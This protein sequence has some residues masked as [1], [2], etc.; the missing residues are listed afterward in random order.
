MKTQKSKLIDKAARGDIEAQR[1]LYARAVESR[2][3]AE[4]LQ[5][6]T[7]NVRQTEI[8]KAARTFDPTNIPERVYKATTW[9]QITK[10]QGLD[11]R[12]KSKDDED[13]DAK[14]EEDEYQA[15]DSKSEEDAD[16][17]E[18]ED[19]RAKDDAD[20]D[21]DEDEVE[22]SRARAGSKASTPDLWAF[23]GYLVKG[24]GPREVYGVV[25]GPREDLDLQACDPTWLKSALPEWMSRGN[26][27]QMH[28]GSM[29]P[30]GKAKKLV[31]AADGDWYLTAK[32]LDDS[33]WKMIQEQ[34]YTGF[35]VGVKNPIVSKS[36]Q[37]RNGLINGGSIIEVSLVDYPAYT[38]SRISTDADRFPILKMAKGGSLKATR[39]ARVYK[40]ADDFV[41]RVGAGNDQGSTNRARITNTNGMPGPKPSD[42]SF[43]PGPGPTFD[44]AD[45][46][47]VPRWS[48][49]LLQ[50]EG[51]TLEQ[52]QAFY[53]W[54]T[55][56]SG[57]Q[58]QREGLTSKDLARMHQL[59]MPSPVTL[60]FGQPLQ[61]AT[62]SANNRTFDLVQKPIDTQYDRRTNSTF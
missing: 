44:Q 41:A 50:A 32:I 49:P 53:A 54:L 51:Y 24:Q 61:A 26:I 18:D 36:S 21:E 58:A 16:E 60:Q 37:F 22:Q 14:D 23:G 10:M 28:S 8:I 4:A 62:D 43:M 59:I 25:S 45:L 57:A 11:Q 55:G 13:E 46:A 29:P 1:L 33:A 42:S 9:A 15:E 30:A 2:K 6:A 5:R 48:D 17:D 56:D 35:S 39:G 3:R 20:E 38:G 19:S 34:V 7:E 27:R 52:A 40:A 47:I 31:Q 12:A